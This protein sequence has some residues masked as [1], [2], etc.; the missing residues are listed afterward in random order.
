[1]LT[2][3]HDSLRESRY[4]WWQRPLCEGGAVKV[5]GGAPGT[6]CDEH[7]ARS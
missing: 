6:T 7:I 2:D 4:C 5:G 1:M 3:V